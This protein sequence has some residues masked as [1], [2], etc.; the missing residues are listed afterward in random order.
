ML[1]A[2]KQLKLRTDFRFDLYVSVD[3][4][5]MTPSVEI[6]LA[7]VSTLSA[8]EMTYTLSG[9]ALNSAQPQP[10]ERLLVYC[11][12]NTVYMW[13]N[14]KRNAL[15]HRC[16]SITTSLSHWHGQCVYVSCDKIVLFDFGFWSWSSQ[17]QSTTSYNIHTYVYTVPKLE[18]SNYTVSQKNRTPV[19][20]SNNSNNPGSV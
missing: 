17:R 3:S 4:P 5:D 14:T 16:L 2:P 7:E 11:A 20:F 1:I 15:Q 8:S 19:T 18:S 9:G 13:N 10:H 6:H 12:E